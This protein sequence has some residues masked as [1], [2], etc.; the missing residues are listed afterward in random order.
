MVAD[1]LHYAVIIPQKR[2]WAS[3]VTLESWKHGSPWFWDDYRRLNADTNSIF[4][5]HLES[6]LSGLFVYIAIDFFYS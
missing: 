3:I 4:K 2:L 6:S 5:Q 1:M